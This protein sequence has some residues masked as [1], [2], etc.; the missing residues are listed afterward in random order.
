[1]EK[2]YQFLQAFFLPELGPQTPRK[3]EIKPLYCTIK[4]PSMEGQNIFEDSL[5][6]VHHTYSS[7]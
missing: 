2:T 4:T 1:M 7:M 6:N 3:M 5:Y